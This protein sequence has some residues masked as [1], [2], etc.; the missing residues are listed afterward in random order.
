MPR[1]MKFLERD[2]KSPY[3]IG[4]SE[5]EE[6][7]CPASG[8][9]RGRGGGIVRPQSRNSQEDEPR[10]VKDRALGMAWWEQDVPHTPDRA[11]Q[12]DRD[13]IK[14]ALDQ[15]KCHPAAP[16]GMRDWDQVGLRAS[17]LIKSVPHARALYYTTLL[18]ESRYY[19]QSDDK[20]K[21]Y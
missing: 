4:R 6:K 9:V 5:R 1:W 3:R 16:C 11:Q 15:E 8:S 14:G 2:D 20:Y 18:L 21:Q 12:S 19:P 17:K 7:L 13:S 10:T